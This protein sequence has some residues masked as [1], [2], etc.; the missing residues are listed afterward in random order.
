MMNSEEFL[1]VVDMGAYA[2]RH[3]FIVEWGDGKLVLRL[4]DIEKK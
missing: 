2:V 3:G 1:K 4:P